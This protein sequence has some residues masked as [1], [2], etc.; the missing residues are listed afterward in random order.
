[1]SGLR[2]D[3]ATRVVYAE[4]AVFGYF[5]YS[6]GPAVPL[7]RTEQGVSAAV[8]SLHGTALALGAVIAGSTSARAAAMIGRGN[9]M[10][11]GVVGISAGIVL[12]TATTF[13]PLTLLGAMVGGTFA[14][15]VVNTH[16]P[17]LSDHH[18]L[19][20]PAAISEASALTAAIG[21]LGPLVI[22]LS[23]HFGLGWR[24]GLLATLVLAVLTLGYSRGVP[25][26][27]RRHDDRLDHSAAAIAAE[28][29]WAAWLVFVLCV[30]IE[31]SMMLWASDLLRHNGLDDGA[32][33][34]AI[35]FMVAGMSI[36]RAIGSRLTARYPIDA[37][38]AGALL[39]NAAGFALF[40]LSGVAWLSIAGLFVVGLG[41]AMQF[42]LNMS[43]VIAASNGRPDLAAARAG[44]GAGLAIGAAPF[45]LGLLADTFG[46]TRAFALVPVLLA[47]TAVFLLAGWRRRRDWP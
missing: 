39:V 41:I 21:V 32:A 43:R 8:S 23:V 33:A 35:L 46:I 36:G 4:L 10:R 17:I 27:D 29:Y 24:G 45:A 26:P 11:L 3:R 22:G 28:P 42:P 44:S 1:L 13:L 38:L 7:L 6:F 19:A 16:A 47:V 9:L 5:L 2:R 31:F 40:W 34:G 15:I 12:F 18:R 25:L 14:S 37:L 30:G 20:G